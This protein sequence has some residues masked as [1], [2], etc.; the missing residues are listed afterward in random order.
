MNAVFNLKMEV[1]VGENL[2]TGVSVKHH[3][4]CIT[5]LCIVMKCWQTGTAVF[6]EALPRPE[7]LRLD[8]LVSI[9]FVTVICDD[10]YGFRIPHDH[11]QMYKQD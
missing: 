10:S 1:T 8:V 3:T 2:L 4:H 6:L 11:C 5:A 7:P 9:E